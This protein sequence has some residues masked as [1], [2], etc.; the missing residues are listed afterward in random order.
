MMIST[1]Q[2]REFGFGFETSEEQLAK[3]NEYC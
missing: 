2:S 1:F 3:V